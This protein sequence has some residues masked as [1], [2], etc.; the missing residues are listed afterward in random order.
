MMQNK[1]I[2]PRKVRSHVVL[3]LALLAQ[4]L[5]L[6]A[7][8]AQVLAAPPGQSPEEGEKTFGQICAACHTIGEGAR[9]GPDLQGVTERREESWLKVHIQNPSVH[10]DQGDPISVANF[11]EFGLRMPALGLSEQQVEGVIAYFGTGESAPRSI[12]DLY[13]PTLIVG[14]LVVLALT[15]LG[16]RVGTKKVEVRP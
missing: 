7:L 4:G 12:P 15:L 11:E 13:A 14:V 6:W 16:L 5:L 2:R 1:A 9:V 10:H 8:A 3:A